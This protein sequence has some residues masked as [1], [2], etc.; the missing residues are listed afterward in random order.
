M[1]GSEDR[2]QRFGRIAVKRPGGRF[3][4]RVRQE[5]VESSGGW[6]PFFPISLVTWLRWRKGERR[7]CAE[8]YVAATSGFGGTLLEASAHDRHAEAMAAATA[9]VR[10]IARGERDS[11]LP[12]GAGA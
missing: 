10:A 8:V 1:W 7:W 9:W 3:I 11:D 5:G 2:L 4:V 12:A 6:P